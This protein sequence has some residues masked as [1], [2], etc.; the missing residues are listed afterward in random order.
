MEFVFV[1]GDGVVVCT[2]ATFSVVARFHGSFLCFLGAR[3]R[4]RESESERVMA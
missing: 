4:E 2:V 3:E 1:R